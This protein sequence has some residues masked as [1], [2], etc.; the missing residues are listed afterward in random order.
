MPGIEPIAA[1]ILYGLLG[2]GVCCA[3]DWAQGHRRPGVE[4][5][6]PQYCCCCFLL[7]TSE[8]GFSTWICSIF[9]VRGRESRK[10]T[11][12]TFVLLFYQHTLGWTG[13]SASRLSCVCAKHKQLSS[14]PGSLTW[15]QEL[16][17]SQLFEAP[18]THLSLCPQTSY[19]SGLFCSTWISSTEVDTRTLHSV[20]LPTSNFTF[21][22]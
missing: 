16:Q 10:E 18:F 21:Y 4:P 2:F 6:E 12:C 5:A 9:K 3:G 1:G 22:R 14:Q 17:G 15:L 20:V 11:V 8:L 13:P 19:C 7:L